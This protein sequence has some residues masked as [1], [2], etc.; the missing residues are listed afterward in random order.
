MAGIFGSLVV[1]V[2]HAMEPVAARLCPACGYALEGLPPSGTCP[3]CGRTYDDAVMVL[4]GF[5]RGGH[6]DSATCRPRSMIGFGL[7]AAI[8]FVPAMLSQRGHMWLVVLTFLLATI[9]VGAWLRRHGSHPGTVQARFNAVGCVQHAN[10]VDPTMHLVALLLLVCLTLFCVAVLPSGRPP[11]LGVWVGIGVF[12]LVAVAV[13]FWQHRRGLAIA[14]RCGLMDGL[15]DDL[16]GTFPVSWA[17]TAAVG[18]ISA[19]PGRFRVTIRSNHRMGT[20]PIDIEIE[21]TRERVD[22]IVERIRLWQS[23]GSDSARGD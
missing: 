21:A 1:D 12:V 22:E 17:D 23:V 18:A 5:A 8:N 13:G 9:G 6:A 7:L 19:G 15:T 16:H 10:R 3:E 2:S 20:T 14:R 4:Y 11:V